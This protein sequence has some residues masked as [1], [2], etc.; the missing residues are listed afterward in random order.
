MFRKESEFLSDLQRYDALGM[1]PVTA[2]EYITNTMK[3]PTGKHPI[4]ITFDDSN[5]DQLRLLPDGS[6]DPKCFFGVWRAFAA[7]HPEFPVKAT[8]FVLPQT[9][10][11]QPKMLKQKLAILASNGCEIANHTVTHPFLNRLTDAAVMKEIAEASFDLK[12]IGADPDAPLALPYGLHPKNRKLLAGFEYQ[13]VMIQPR[14]VF[15][16]GSDP[17]PLPT[18]PKFNHLEI[19]RIEASHR[20]EALDYWLDRAESGKVK[21]ATAE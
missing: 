9:M 1:V 7:S 21:L 18:S 13:G 6:V 19:P 16:V 20:E 4:V 3:V 14:G 2:S 15:L 11:L 5:P 17:A 12:R 10:F 8:F